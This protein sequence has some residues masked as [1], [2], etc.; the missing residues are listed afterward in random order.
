[1][2]FDCRSTGTVPGEP[3]R[4]LLLPQ[5]ERICLMVR[6]D[7]LGVHELGL[8]TLNEALNFVA[9]WLPRGDEADPRE[10]VDPD[11]LLASSERS[12][13]ISVTRYTTEGSAEIAGAST[14][15][16]LARREG[17]LH[18][19]SREPAN[20]AALVPRPLDGEDVRETL[21]LLLGYR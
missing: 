4:I 21:T 15:L 7:A 13:L 14:D 16:I 6:I 20:R 17:K 2:V 10:A 3:W 12:A 1:M 19:F 5:P 11:A 18:A 8:Y 9:D